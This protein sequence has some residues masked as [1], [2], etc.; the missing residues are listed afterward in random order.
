MMCACNIIKQE[1]YLRHWLHAG[2]THPS[3]KRN[4]KHITCVFL[5]LLPYLPDIRESTVQ[6]EDSD[7]KDYAK[8]SM[9]KEINLD[10]C[11]QHLQMS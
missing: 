2:Q 8:V 1:N 9:K 3:G 5:F 4:G 11:F 6:K 7:Y 10:F